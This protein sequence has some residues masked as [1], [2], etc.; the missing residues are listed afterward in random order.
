MVGSRPRP[1]P[2]MAGDFVAGP[3]RLSGPVVHSAPARLPVSVIDYLGLSEPFSYGALLLGSPPFPGQFLPPPKHRRPKSGCARRCPS[4][5][6]HGH[7][8]RAAVA[9]IS[10][11][12][13]GRPDRIYSSHAAAAVPQHQQQ[14]MAQLDRSYR[15]I[16][17]AYH[18]QL[19]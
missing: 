11:Q 2:G 7:W 8:E 17:S 6:V 15:P 12:S 14:L 19:P 3:R 4:L 16:G 1:R 18:S 9:G 10:C 13:P 5:P